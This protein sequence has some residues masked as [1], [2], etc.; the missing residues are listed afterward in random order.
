[1]EYLVDVIVP[2]YNHERYIEVT[3]NSMVEQITDFRYRV[4]PSDDCSTDGTRAILRRLAAAHPDKIFPVYREKNGGAIANGYSLLN[5]A[6]AKYVA[7]CDG[8]DYWIDPHKLQKQV[9]FLEANPDFSMCFTD[10]KIKDE[11]GLN[12]PRER[13]FAR[14]E[15]DVFTIEDFILADQQ[16]VPTLTIMVRNVMPKPVPEF[17]LTILSGDIFIQIM[18]A[19]KGKAKYMDEQMGVYRN[20]SGGV[21]KSEENLRK[22][23]EKLVEMYLH[24]NEYLGRR[25]EKTFRQRLLALAKTRLIYEAKGKTGLA[26]LSHYFR[27]MPDYIKYSEKINFKELAYYHVVL[28]FPFLLKEKS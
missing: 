8:D 23:D 3:L 15:K 27:R 25:Y 19:D 6:T 12:Q 9:D 5:A 20:N 28:F 1:M 21:T 11:T 17:Y 7:I 10:V 16:I 24:L 2:V 22:G 13:F 4:I 18:T 14:L 26:K